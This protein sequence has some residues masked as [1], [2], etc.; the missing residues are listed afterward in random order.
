M[1]VIKLYRNVFCYFSQVSERSG[2]I[3]IIITI[4]KYFE[5]AIAPELFFK[6]R[7]SKK[8]RKT[9]KKTLVPKSLF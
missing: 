6:K 3:K 2:M 5:A 4:L 7:Y 8:F 9:H 1:N